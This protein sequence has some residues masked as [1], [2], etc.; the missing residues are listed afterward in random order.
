[1][2]VL[3]L[4]HQTLTGHYTYERMHNRDISQKL[5]ETLYKV[6]PAYQVKVIKL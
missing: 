2:E 1:M 5:I 6:V 3:I 4:Q